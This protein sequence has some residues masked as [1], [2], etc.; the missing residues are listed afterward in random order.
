[1]GLIVL[2]TQKVDGAVAASND[3]KLKSSNYDGAHRRLDPEYLS[4]FEI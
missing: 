2:K 4:A 3:D 1:M